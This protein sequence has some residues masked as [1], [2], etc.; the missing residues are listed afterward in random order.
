MIGHRLSMTKIV[1][2]MAAVILVGRGACQ[3]T[4][5]IWQ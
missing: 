1:A 5:V 3:A 4:P 2:A